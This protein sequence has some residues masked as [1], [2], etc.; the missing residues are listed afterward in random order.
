MRTFLTASALVSAALFCSAAQAQTI[1][2][3]DASVYDRAAARLPRNRDLIL[4]ARIAPHWRAG[5]KSFTYRRN[6]GDGRAEFVS[7]DAATGKRSA[8]FDQALVAA[9]LSGAL[10]RTVAPDQLPF[11]DFDAVGPKAIRV[12]VGDQR[13][14]CLTDK[15]QCDLDASPRAGPNEI[16]SPN[17]RWIAYRK[18]YNLWVRSLDGKTNF[19]LTQDG[20]LYNAY[21]V[22]TQGLLSS[23]MAD[24]VDH[25]GRDAAGR[26]TGIPSPFEV[27]WSPDSSR[28]FVQKLDE[29]QVR[30]LTIT[31]MTPPD[32][33]VSPK[34]VT[35]KMA[36][37]DD[38][39]I[40]TLVSY[41]FDVDGRTGRKIAIDPIPAPL[42]T[43]LQNQKAWWAADN[44]SLYIL[45][46]SRYLKSLS[47]D[48]IDPSTG[49]ARRL[50]TETTKTFITP[51]GGL[52]HAPMV[53]T[54]ASGDLIWFSERTG[55]GH[56]Y[57]YDG[58]TGVLK[59]DLTPGDWTV[60]D[61]VR[62]DEARGVIYV[63]GQEREP[64]QDPYQ[65]QI[66]Q[67]SLRNG[68][69]KRVTPEAADHEVFGVQTLGASR[70]NV[71][72]FVSFSPSGDYFLDAVSRV[73][74]PA[75]TI[76]R[77]ADGSQVAVVETT[78][79]SRLTR[80][81]FTPP[82]RFEVLA[83]D[84][85]TRLYGEILKP[86]DFDPNK[87]YPVLDV[88]YPGPQRHQ[89][90]GRFAEAALNDG[91]PFA[92]LGFIVIRFDGRGTEGRSKAF[93]DESYGS[94]ASGG[95]L[96]DHVTAIRE[97]ARRYAYIDLDRVG[98]S[99]IS[100]GGYGAAR[101][102]LLFPDFFKVAVSDAGSHDQRLIVGGWGETFIG[103][104]NGSN[105]KESRNATYAGNLKGKLLLLQ[106]DMD[107]NVIPS[108]TLQ[109]ADALV[110]A[111]K[112]FELK[113]FSNIGHASLLQSGYALKYAWDFLVT[114]LMKAEPPKDYVL[115]TGL[116]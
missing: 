100:A 97:L 33:S 92:E 72:D 109:F 15:A 66:Y 78:D 81:G 29:R 52:F 51:G 19:A 39:V 69:I 11:A 54:L 50:I 111:N 12:E 53:Y 62:L 17:G 48:V 14:V 70:P 5:G 41:V 37:P 59:R 103:P 23:D 25:T 83:G 24:G 85:K 107:T 56:L 49:A 30:D 110:K 16:A 90:S 80:I 58:K 36:L 82:E 4:N 74:L 91:T 77:R 6:L 76:L 42:T 67:V 84:G 32:G 44:H 112:P 95:H 98:I 3:I 10:K 13:L 18:D 40:P 114:N 105:Y 79:Y 89:A 9:G 47:L 96:D 2:K 34:P 31:Q 115:K 73:D 28:I 61:V 55:Y 104:D 113:M 38:P 63:T 102:I 8:A 99:G 93:L 108:Q 20:E 94:L 35:W 60:R 71:A 57:L 65:R 26:S 21:A 43:T 86:S 87:R 64:G 46:Q 7:V 88:V 22:T 101:G 45:T 27:L 68:A 116:F 1:P 106:G 75:K